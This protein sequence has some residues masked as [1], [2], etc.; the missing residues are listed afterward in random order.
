MNCRRL[1]SRYPPWLIFL[2]VLGAIAHYNEY[3]ALRI[4]SC[5]WR[6]PEE[7]GIRVMLVADPQ[8]VGYQNEPKWL[9]AFTRWDSDRYMSNAFTVAYKI[10]QPDMV[11]FL[12]DLIDEMVFANDAEREWAI[13][14]F[15]EAFP[16]FDLNTTLI[17]IPGDNDIGGE[18]EPVQDHL[19]RKFAD[20]FPNYYSNRATDKLLELSMVDSLSDNQ[21]YR[22]SRA[23]GGLP[24][25]LSHLPMIRSFIK[26]IFEQFSDESY[27]TRLVLSAHDHV[28]EYY[29]QPEHDQR[30]DRVAGENGIKFLFAKGNK[31]SVLEIQVPTISYRMGVPNMAIGVLG[32][33]NSSDGFHIH[34]ENWWLPSRYPQLYVYL[35]YIAFVFAYCVRKLYLSVSRRS[36]GKPVKY[37]I[38]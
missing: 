4:R 23:P 20:K 27:E 35:V 29:I 38:V 12:G 10:L 34:Y 36:D 17:F 5:F 31:N 32:V 6:M 16:Q 15:Y 30:F 8:L 25:M 26:P 9:G 1:V 11:I 37:S 14:R 24:V 3:L 2:V 13:N 21:L 7:G 33:R 28:S 19:R 18:V 22:L